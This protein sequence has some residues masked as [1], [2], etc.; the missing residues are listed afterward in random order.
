VWDALANR[1]W[2][3]DIS[4]APTAAVWIEYVQLWDKVD[5]IQFQPHTPDRLVWKWTASGEY[6][7]SS[8]YRAFFA[9]TT[10]LLGAKEVWK[11]SAPSKVKFFFWLALHGHLWTAERRKRHGLQQNDVC[12]LCD[13]AVESTDHLLAACVFSREVW[14][15]LLLLAGLHHL[16]PG[17]DSSLVDWWHL[18]RTQVP[19]LFRRGFDSLVLLVSWETWKERNRRT[20]DGI[21]K[22]PAE[23][24]V[25]ISEEGDSWIAAGFKSL[26][27]LFA[28]AG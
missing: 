16:C 9:R 18:V 25:S 11:A 23:V 26:T 12:A 15:R 7:S 1:Q 22:T 19:N 4:G 5:G 20:F 24:L 13:Q 27:P 28:L 8:A 21:T 6:S 10:S 3:R 17:S 2:A 14:Y